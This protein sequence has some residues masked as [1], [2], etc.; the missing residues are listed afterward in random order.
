MYQGVASV[1]DLSGQ[2]LASAALLCWEVD[3]GTY[4]IG[5]PAV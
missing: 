2:L 1:L 4:W 3:P 5:V